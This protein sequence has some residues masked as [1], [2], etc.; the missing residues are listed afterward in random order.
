[1]ADR[2]PYPTDV[3]DEQWAR[4]EPLLPAAKTGGRHRKIDLREVINTLFYQDKTGCQW[5]MLPHD[6]LPKSTVWDYFKAWKTDGTWQKIVDALRREVRTNAGRESDP[7]VACIDT[8]T[9]ATHHQGAE[10][11]KDGFKLIKGR[12]RHIV[13]DS[14]GLL[15]AVAVTAGAAHD[16]R[17]APAVLSKLDAQTKRRLEVIFADAK[18][19]GEFLANWIIENGDCYHLVIGKKSE[20]KGFQPEH[21]RWVVER[22]YAWLGYS[23]RLSKDYERT[24]TSSEA[25]VQVSS[26]RLMLRRVTNQKHKHGFTYRSNA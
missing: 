2:K 12:K 11:S 26:I 23:R 25:W 24:T 4:I 17:S 15:L 14:L 9:V 3:S 5:A 6:L 10:S 1:M 19:Q 7:S 22:T 13:V 20:K 21:V 18:Y 16:G 8:Q